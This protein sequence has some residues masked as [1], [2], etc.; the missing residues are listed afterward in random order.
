MLDE[1]MKGNE[2]KTLNEMLDI[3]Q[4]IIAI[5]Q[6]HNLSHKQG[7]FTLLFLAGVSA[8]VCQRPILKNRW[9]D[10]AWLGWQHGASYEL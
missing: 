6:K 4:E 5:F 8:G 1:T 10:P 2:M 9:I 7:E 3:Q